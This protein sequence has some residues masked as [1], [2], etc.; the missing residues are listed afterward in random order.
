MG[1]PL[2][3]CPACG[4]WLDPGETCD[5]QDETAENTAPVAGAEAAQQAVAEPC[6]KIANPPLPALAV[7]A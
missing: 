4:A 5:C 3:T 7:G 6:E 1:N 2:R